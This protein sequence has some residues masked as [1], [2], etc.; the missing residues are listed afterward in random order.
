[1][2][3]FK[4]AFD[5]LFK[6]VSSYGT[7]P[8]DEP[9]FYEELNKLIDNYGREIAIEFAQNEK[10]PEYTFEL[11]TKSGLREIPKE[12]LLP[13][14]RTDNADNMYCTAFAL[15]ACGYDEGF[16]ILKSFASQTHPL[17]KSIHPT[18]D[19]LPDLSFIN[20][21]RV[22]EIKKFCQEHS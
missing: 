18:E 4:N 16:N 11:L 3:N 8:D 17:S 10:C 2:T 22:N 12:I 13:Y 7:S 6:Q 1:M 19:I 9:W 21:S 15:A 20:D 5:K 14:L